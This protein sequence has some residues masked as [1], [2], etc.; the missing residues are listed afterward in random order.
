[1]YAVKL[2]KLPRRGSIE[3][4]YY[5]K[6]YITHLIIMYE[7]VPAPRSTESFGE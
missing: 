1:M 5:A 3:W 4:H 7:K 2:R 6:I